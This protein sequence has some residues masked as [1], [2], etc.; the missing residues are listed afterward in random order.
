[1]F[2][3]III[4]GLSTFGLSTFFVLADIFDDVTTLGLTTISDFSVAILGVLIMFL[5]ALTLKLF[6]KDFI[7]LLLSYYLFF[8]YIF[9]HR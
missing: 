2:F 8:H 7:L 3:S 9:Y 5:V 1:M 6:S 4:F